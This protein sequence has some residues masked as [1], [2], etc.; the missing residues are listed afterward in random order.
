[1]IFLL[2]WFQAVPDQGVRYYHISTHGNRTFCQAALKNASI[3]VNDK[4][5]TIECVGVVVND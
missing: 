3:I 2:I 4:T 1:M 5:E